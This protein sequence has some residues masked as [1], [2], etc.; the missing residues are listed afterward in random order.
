MYG[1]ALDTV[2]YVVRYAARD[3]ARDTVRDTVRHAHAKWH[4]ARHGTACDVV[5]YATGR[6][7]TRNGMRS[8][9][10]GAR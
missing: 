7:K 4:G 9:T 10:Y 5:W 8:G 6:Y 1:T 2:R 3:T